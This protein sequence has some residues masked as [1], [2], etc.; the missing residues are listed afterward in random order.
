MNYKRVLLKLTGQV[1]GEKGI[2]F[3]KTEKLAKYL[4]ELQQKTG[5]E[6][7]LVLG[8]G[9]IFR[10]RQVTGT[11]FDKVIADYI[12]MTSTV[13]NALA[14]QGK[15]EELRGEVAV[16][17]AYKIGE[18]CETFSRDKAVEKLKKGK[19][20]ILAGGTG[21]PF[22]TT[23]SGAAL[24]ASE[25]NCDVILKGSNV[26]G[27]YDTDPKKN[28]DAK[29]YDTLTYEE[30]LVKNL[31]VMDTTA[32]ALCQN[33]KIPIIVFNAD[34]LENIEKIILGEKIGTLV[35]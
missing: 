35:S 34:N 3:E 1:F 17:S 10:G 19:I 18:I 7:A 12:G 28:P 4:I 26:E 9:N 15:I 11:D 22:F 32:F 30:A 16:M 24:K 8:G 31:Q 20:L 14:L 27:I 25:L 21:N 23:D 2:D 13:L 29:M 6:L 33:E 5:I